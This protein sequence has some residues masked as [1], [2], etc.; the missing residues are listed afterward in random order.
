VCR[1]DI[2]AS[3]MSRHDDAAR[4]QRRGDDPPDRRGW[5]SEPECHPSEGRGRN[6]S[7]RLALLNVHVCPGV[8]P[9]VPNDRRTPSR[10]DGTGR[11]VAGIAR[12]QLV[13]DDCDPPVLP[14]RS[15]RDLIGPR[16]ADEVRA[17]SSDPVSD[18]SWPVA[19]LRMCPS[20]S[21]HDAGNSRHEEEEP[22]HVTTVDDEDAAPVST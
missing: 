12:L 18:P 11:A 2:P 4:R 16:G 22:T 14:P 17:E 20:T 6:R 3:A 8:R 13:K 9:C 7:R 15:P 1:P 5:A 19:G 21:D 10:D